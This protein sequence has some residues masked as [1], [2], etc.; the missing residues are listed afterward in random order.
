MLFGRGPFQGGSSAEFT[1]RALRAAADAGVRVTADSEKLNEVVQE[2]FGLDLEPIPMSP[3]TDPSLLK[4]RIPQPGGPIRVIA[5]GYPQAVRGFDSVA[6]LSEHLSSRIA[7]GSL[8][9]TARYTWGRTPELDDHAKR[10]LDN[11][12]T[13]IEGH[14]LSP[15]D[16]A[17]MIRDA[18]VALLPYRKAAFQARTSGVLLDLLATGVPVVATANSWSGC[19]LSTHGIGRTFPDRDA[20]AMCAAIDAVI[21]DFESEADAVVA[22]WSRIEQEYRTE[23]LVDFLTVPVTTGAPLSI[24]RLDDLYTSLS[25]LLGDLFFKD[26]EKDS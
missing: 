7:D 19:L 8:S 26:S 1:K 25:L 17:E 12:A 11:G 13:L 6:Q 2:R 14:S 3:V 15:S 4:P 24:E 10:L 16:Y 23:S 20:A 18:D 9:M 21:A 22:A 5:P